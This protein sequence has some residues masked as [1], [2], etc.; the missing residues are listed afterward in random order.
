VKR[1]PIHDKR[2][3]RICIVC[4]K[5]LKKDQ[6]RFMVAI[7]GRTVPVNFYVH[8]N[9]RCNDP[10]RIRKALENEEKASKVLNFEV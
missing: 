9:G 6:K 8:R 10:E 4:D 2:I 7:D 5:Q 3:R 1:K